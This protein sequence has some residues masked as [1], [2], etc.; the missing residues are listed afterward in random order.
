MVAFAI[1][2]MKST[3]DILRLAMNEEKFLAVWHTRN[4]L[5]RMVNS[6]VQNELIK[7]LTASECADMIRLYGAFVENGAKA[8]IADLIDQDSAKRS[9]R[10]ADVFSSDYRM[11]GQFISPAD[12][13][14]RGVTNELVLGQYEDWKEQLIG[15]HGGAVHGI[16]LKQAAKADV[17]GKIEK[18][19][20][21]HRGAAIS[22]TT[23]DTIFFLEHFSAA[24][25]EELDPVYYMLPLGTI[26][27]NYHHALA[28]VAMTLTLNGVLDYSMGI[29]STLVPS[30]THHRLAQHIRNE[31]SF[32]ENRIDNKLM[33]IYYNGNNIEGCYQFETAEKADFQRLAKADMNL[34]TTFKGFN[35]WPSEANILAL[36][37]QNGL[38]AI[39]TEAKRRGV[40]VEEI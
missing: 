16:Q 35:E 10:Q 34:W 9:K 25:G 3:P 33:L 2:E 23:A 18:T 7:K 36:L 5:S 11:R 29:Y 38:M 26:V 28:E 24:I 31:L 20:G 19:F 22:G 12:K 15:G 21:L 27:Y 1:N 14:N 39:A 17:I 30:N 6:D 13:I 37:R 40:N 4:E 32:L 8:K